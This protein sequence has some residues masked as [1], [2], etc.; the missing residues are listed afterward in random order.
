MNTWWWPNISPRIWVTLNQCEPLEGHTFSTYGWPGACPSV[1]L[2]VHLEHGLPSVL[3]VLYVAMHSEICSD[4]S[5]N[6]GFEMMFVNLQV[7]LWHH[8]QY[9]DAKH[10]ETLLAKR[11]IQSRAQHHHA[12]RAAGRCDAS[13]GS[14]G[15]AGKCCFSLHQLI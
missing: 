5:T 14:K 15:P 13:C 3:V 6:T 10:C 8:F 2:E 1:H 9:P 4:K 12:T 11:P 7:C